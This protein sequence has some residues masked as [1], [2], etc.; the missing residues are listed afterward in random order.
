MRNWHPR[1]PM[2]LVESHICSRDRC[3]RCVRPCVGSRAGRGVPAWYVAR[4]RDGWWQ[5]GCRRIFRISTRTLS[6]TGF[7]VVGPTFVPRM[8]WRCRRRSLPVRGLEL[9]Q[10][11]LCWGND[12]IRRGGRVEWVARSFAGTRW[13]EPRGEAAIAYQINTYRV[14]LT[15]A[16]YETVIWVPEG[17]PRDTTRSPAEFDAIARFLMECGAPAVPHAPSEERV[18]PALT[19]LEYDAGFP[20][21]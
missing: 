6:P 13:Q 17:D 5:M 14:L 21:I 2:T 3:R 4:V 16:R 9:D 19:L 18:D 10:V 1:W 15:R 8:R 7:C 20:L 11:G 12:L